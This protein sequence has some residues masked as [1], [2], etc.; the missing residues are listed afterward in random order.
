MVNLIVEFLKF[1]S[2]FVL[3]VW[4]IGTTYVCYMYCTGQLDDELKENKTRY[5]KK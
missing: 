1:L 5:S 4:V 3:V 2:Y